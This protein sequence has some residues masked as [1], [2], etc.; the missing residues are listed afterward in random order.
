MTPFTIFRVLSVLLVAFVLAACGGGGS[1][2]SDSPV[3]S[4]SGEASAAA[5]EVTIADL[6]YDPANLEVAAGTEVTW[7]ND[8][9]APH[10]VSFDDDAV[11]DSEELAKGDT[12]SVTFDEAG[13]FSYVCAI[14]P[15][16]K[17]TVTVQ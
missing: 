9:D 8:D 17:A 16:M 1:T 4:G 15:D 12:F 3:A 13:E 5:G 10:T 2:G 6:K 7:T 11:T 14:H